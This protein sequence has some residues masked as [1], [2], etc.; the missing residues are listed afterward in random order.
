MLVVLVYLQPFWRNLFLK[1]VLQLKIAKKIT[2]TFYF[3]GTRSLNIINVNIPKKSS[4]L[5]VT[6]NSMVV[7]I[8]NYFYVK[9]AN[10]GRITP[11]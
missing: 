4:P 2:K 1:C 11:F 6:I 3:W 5:P 10:N 8:C 9:R 7:P